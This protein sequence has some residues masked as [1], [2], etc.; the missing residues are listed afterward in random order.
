MNTITSGK[1]LLSVVVPAMLMGCQ[2]T[3]R[4]AGSKSVVQE[5]PGLTS[6]YRA[7]ARR[8]QDPHASTRLPI[9]RAQKRNL[10]IL[11]EQCQQL[12]ADAQAWDS[13]ARLTSVDAADQD[14][15]RA[16]VAA[17]R[18]SLEQL[19]AAAA[20]S[21]IPNVR[22]HYAAAVSSYRR[23]LEMTDTLN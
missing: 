18:D 21:R 3:Q 22:E 13:D 10:R 12:L 20:K 6:A 23:L 17:F 5:L 11:T 7:A 19:S 14:E 2:S 16:T 15:L 1:W 9:R 8:R 4:V